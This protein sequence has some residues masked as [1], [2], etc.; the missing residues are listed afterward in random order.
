MKLRKEVI[1]GRFILLLTFLLTTTLGVYAQNV[2]V[3]GSIKDPEGKPISG[4][5]VQVENTPNIGTISDKDGNFSL[6]VP[7]GTKHLVIGHIGMLQKRSDVVAGQLLNV[8]LEPEDKKLDEI[9]VIGYQTM[10]RKDLTGAVASVSGKDISSIPVSNA[11]QALQ[12]KL[13]GV[14]VVSQDGRPDASIA[15]RVRGGSSISQSND[16][17]ILVD[18][19]IVG[20]L[21]DIPV[22]QI[23]SIDVLKDAA[24]TAIYG[25]RGANG[26]IL[27]TTKGAKAGKTTVSYNGYGKVNTPVKYMQAM[28]PY[29]Y[30][31]YV[32]ANAAANGTAYQT[33]FEQLYGIGAYTQNNP[34]GIESYKNTPTYN[35]QKMVYN[36]SFSHN[37]DIS[38][39]G[40]SDK[41]KVL[42]T[43]NYID[44]QGM[45]VNS[46]F[47]RANITLKA[48]QKLYDNVDVN[49]DTRYTDTRDLGDEGTTNGSGS[50]LSSAYQ[51]RPIATSNI[52]GDLSALQSGNMEQYGKTTTWDEYNPYN[53]IKDYYPLALG[54]TLRGTISLNWRIIARLTYHTDFNLNKG[55]DQDRIWGGAI[56]NNYLDPVTGEKLYAGSVDYDKSD[57]WGSRWTNTLNY[58]ADF[59]SKHRLN[60]LIGQEVSNSGGTDM[61][62]TAN[63]FPANFTMDNAFA[64]INQYDQTAGTSS[65]S[66]GISI[67]N[68]IFSL[69]GRANYTFM[70][71]YLFTLTFRGDASS[72]FAPLH[73]WG[74]FP[75]AAAA[76]RLSQE[77]FM[78][79]ISWISNLKL[80]LSYG[81]VGN[82]GINSSLWSQLWTSETDRRLE[83]VINNQYQSAY[84]LASAQMA[85]PN[86]KWETSITRNLGVDFDLF[87]SRLSGTIDLYKN[88]TKDLLMLTNIPGITG[89]TSTYANIGQISNRGLEISLSGT[90]FQNKDW[91]VT[92]GGNINFNKNNV[93]RL[94]NNVTGLYGT[95]WAS[96]STYP[97]ADY[98]LET[99]HPVGLVRGLTYDGFYTTKDFNY[100]NGVYTLKPGVADVGSFIGVVHGIGATERPTGQTAYP[101]VVKYKDLNGDGVIDDNDLSVIGNTNP[102]HT[103]GFNI[104]ATYKNIDFGAY[105]NWSYGNDI[106]DAT[107]L[108]ALYGYKE[109]A[110]YQNKLAMLNN[111]YK[112][113]DVQNGQL[114]RLSTPEELDAANTHAT[115]PLAY[116]ENGVT[117]T[118]GIENGSYL[119]LNT[120]V[121]GYTIPKRL[122]KKTGISRLRIYG[123][124]YNV[125]TITGY[126]GL[127]PEVNTNTSQGHAAY[128]TTGLDWG[129]YP[130]A[131]SFVF[132]LNL[133]F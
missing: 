98:I 82:D 84:D 131:R 124:I 56:Y 71:R 99:G 92:A 123:S 122:M 116:N 66:S 72:R 75:A 102:K 39:A 96:T 46:S 3:R 132:G 113:Y 36:Q 38:I 88:T 33:P 94:A 53:I 121:L 16:P 77:S 31:R 37:H 8:I 14:N 89:F 20:S 70:D 91:N 68:R 101:G 61:R 120:L 55:W 11:A 45:K 76:W 12:G 23:A 97:A 63:H 6:S 29:D 32:W 111:S 7:G 100:A 28:G 112:I 110:V 10:K 127:D 43:A 118:L 21:S 41:T 26:V 65:F 34:G 27:V 30:L 47:K 35:V 62:I 9:V 17:L 133:N 73:R 13:P 129:A 60:V 80:R 40:G 4:A 1:R 104:S 130:R 19:V 58:D 5:T 69:F 86:L 79:D 117:S 78:K 51:F 57:S 105:L 18:G 126:S 49:I 83:Y 59:G 115:L 42:F 67:P 103:G 90:L 87:G 119:R 64:M 125:L 22:D 107:K 24:S 52:L 44:E 109:N 93:D 2:V 25:A 114:V 128:P 54:Q 81:E 85:N 108:A 48:S 50:L 106:Y 74:Y 15:I 95:Q